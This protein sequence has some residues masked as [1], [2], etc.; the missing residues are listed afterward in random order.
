MKNLFFFVF[1]VILFS[2]CKKEEPYNPDEHIVYTHWY[3]LSNRSADTLYSVYFPNA[4]TPNGDGTNDNFKPLGGFVLSKFQIFSKAGQ[5][6]FET[7]DKNKAWNGRMN[8]SGDRI[9]MGSYTFLLK[10]SDIYGEQYEYNGSV[11]L[12][13]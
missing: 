3:K 7:A 6:V 13:K 12:Y 5:I 9:Q 2:S 4:F 10:V 1:I 8:S 11:M